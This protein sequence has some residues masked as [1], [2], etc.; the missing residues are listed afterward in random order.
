MN[1]NVISKRYA[2]SKFFTEKTDQAVS[3]KNTLRFYFIEGVYFSEVSIHASI[4][5]FYF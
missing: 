2:Y 1:K 5:L 4:F 3:L